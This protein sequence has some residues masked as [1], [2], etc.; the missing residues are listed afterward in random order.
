MEETKSVSQS[1]SKLDGDV[2]SWFYC[3]T[4]KILITKCEENL[5][6]V[7]DISKI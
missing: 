1:F 4:S 5:K 3:H 2:V 7:H 6:Y